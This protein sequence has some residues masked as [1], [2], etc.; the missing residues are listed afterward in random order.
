MRLLHTKDLRLEEFFDAQIPKYAILSHRWEEDEVTYQ[1][2]LD[3]KKQSG[4]GSQKIVNCCRVAAYAGYDW[5]WI[6]TCCIDKKSS[7]ELSEAI[8]SMFRWY[9]NS[10]V[11][12]AYLSDV[13]E[14]SETTTI[15]E[16]LAYFHLSL[17]F[18]RGW[19][20]QELL[21]PRRLIFLNN[22]WAPVQSRPPP[23]GSR[24]LLLPELH[25][26]PDGSRASLLQEV[27]EATGIDRQYIERFVPTQELPQD[28]FSTSLCTST[29]M[30]WAASRETSRVEDMSYC[31]LGLFSI[32]MPLLYGEG[33]A[34]FRRLQM[35]II[36]KTTDE[37]IF[38]WNTP[39]DEGPY[40]DSMLAPS[41]A[42]FADA[43][44]TREDHTT[45]F[46][47]HY[48]ITNR[49]LLMRVLTFLQV[50]LSDKSNMYG[51]G[52]NR[53]VFALRCCGANNAIALVPIVECFTAQRDHAVRP[54]TE[55]LEILYSRDGGM[56]ILW[57]SHA[58]LATMAR[59]Q[60][61]TLKS[62]P[63]KDLSDR[64]FGYRLWAEHSRMIYLKI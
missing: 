55:E 9:R 13:P 21:A 39:D 17:W 11:C 61:M 18:T 35:E 48:A 7:A 54:M 28:K 49:G 59:R 5:V 47:G 16:V 57:S 64:E 23:D 36:A 14:V 52:S 22:S 50:R 41:P 63:S 29:I 32:N 1:E 45:P 34:A 38:V 10:E 15:E 51:G 3:G 6:D 43:W 2:W 12:F 27:Y 44:S 46:R 60:K 40:R 56:R 4:K 25:E 30:S 58:E 62:K 26:P 53:Y 42:C 31:L 33:D 8:N 20:L 19:T 37:T 24:A